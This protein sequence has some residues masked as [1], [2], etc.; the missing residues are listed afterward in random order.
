MTLPDVSPRRWIALRPWRRHSLVLALGGFVYIAVGII[1]MGTGA[2][3]SRTRSLEVALNVAP[4]EVW[5]T[6][7][8]LAGIAGVISGR[9]PPASEKWGYTVMSS[10]AALWAA[11]YVLGVFFLEAPDH[12]LSGGAV[13]ALVALLWW[14]ISGLENPGRVMRRG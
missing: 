11:G 7:W 14:G 3:R 10:L 9:W 13:W 6:I 4:I 5:G 8:F 1:Y 12:A 2:D